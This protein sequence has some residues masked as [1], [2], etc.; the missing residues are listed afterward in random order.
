MAA[1]AT[2][3]DRAAVADTSELSDLTVIAPHSSEGSHVIADCWGLHGDWLTN[4]KL[5]EAS[6]VH[7]AYAA[8]AK[9]L[10]SHFHHFGPN[11]GVTG[12]LLLAESHC[13]IH[14]WPE[15][16]MA[17]F[18]I[19]ICGETANRKKKAHAALETLIAELNP[20]R[21]QQQTI[22]RGVLA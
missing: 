14:T 10:G 2:V 21:V 8:D 3:V 18:D 19:F 5:I 15:Y 4:P 9:I 6:L 11:Q 7:A 17:A 1:V 12:V 22:V 20:V 13:S 16:G